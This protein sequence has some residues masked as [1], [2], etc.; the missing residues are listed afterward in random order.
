MRRN[1]RILLLVL[2]AV[3][4]LFACG[5]DDD[6]SSPQRQV[7]STLSMKIN[8]VDW[9]ASKNVS[10]SVSFHSS[11]GKTDAAIISGA[12]NTNQS[13]QI[14]TAREIDGPGTYEIPSTTGGGISLNY[15]GKIY[16]AKNLTIVIDEIKTV[17]TSKFVRGSF[18]GV[19][20]YLQDEQ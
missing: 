9:T 6:G 17:N 1:F 3:V 7:S 2:Y 10:A 14:T 20:R 5:G 18:S 12:D 13:I 19:A 11:D 8:G 4:I 16:A 15:G